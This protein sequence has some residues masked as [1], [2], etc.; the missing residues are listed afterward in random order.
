[1]AIWLLYTFRLQVRTES[2]RFELDHSCGLPE[3]EEGSGKYAGDVFR[4]G[5]EDYFFLS[6]LDKCSLM[7][8]GELIKEETEVSWIDKDLLYYFDRRYE[9]GD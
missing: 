7:R 5:S 8:S 6:Y 9:E 3:A 2:T 4:K 1:M